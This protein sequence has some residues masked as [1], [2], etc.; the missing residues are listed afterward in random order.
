M[1]LYSE[2]TAALLVAWGNAMEAEFKALCPCPIWSK[3]G[4]VNTETGEVV[5][6]CPTC[7]A[8]K[9]IVKADP[10]EVVEKRRAEHDRMMAYMHALGRACAAENDRIIAEAFRT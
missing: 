1:K 5:I 9:T 2:E 3:G 8:S 7:K 6:T 4:T 10:P